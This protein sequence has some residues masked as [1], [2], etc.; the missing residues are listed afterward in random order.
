MNQ[1]VKSYIV[2]SA[3]WEFEVDELD[4]E[5]AV[6]TATFLAF[7]KSGNKLMLSTVIMVN[8]KDDHLNDNISQANFFPT[9][10]ILKNIGLDKLSRSFQELTLSLNEF[11]SIN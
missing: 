7:G 9:Y 1:K 2:S 8:S 5:S 3:D 10:K 6:N 11:K 4:D